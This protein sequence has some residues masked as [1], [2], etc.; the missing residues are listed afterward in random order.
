MMGKGSKQVF[1]VFS[2]S[3]DS[4]LKVWQKVAKKLYLLSMDYHKNQKN[5]TKTSKTKL[6]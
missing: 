6:I 5:K 1:F 2:L 3:V 4:F